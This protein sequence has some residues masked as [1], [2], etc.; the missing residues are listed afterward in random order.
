MA[1]RSKTVTSKGQVAI[2]K[3]IR[4]ALNI[5]LKD[6]VAFELVEGEIR[7]KR[8][9]SRLLAGYGA[10]KPKAMPETFRRMRQEVEEEWGEEV[11]K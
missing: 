7:L 5:R 10:V 6:Q 11:G 3:E 1:E 4:R 8:V 9:R 2:L